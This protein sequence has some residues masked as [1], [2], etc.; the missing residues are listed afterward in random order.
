MRLNSIDIRAEDCAP[1][2][3]YAV[4]AAVSE[5]QSALSLLESNAERLNDRLMPVLS[6]E[7]NDSTKGSVRPIHS[8][9]LA[10]ELTAL[11]D[12]IEELNYRV[13]DAL[14]RLHV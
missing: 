13:L 9:P 14:D 10:G 8:V 11:V 12:R 6:G 7:R 3:E 1:P 2:T 4:P 5:L